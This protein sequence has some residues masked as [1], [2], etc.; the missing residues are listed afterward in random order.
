MPLPCKNAYLQYMYPD[1]M[2]S[3]QT[4]VNNFIIFLIIFEPCIA[5]YLYANRSDQNKQKSQ[6]GPGCMA[7]SKI[8]HR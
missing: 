3:G 2:A 1:Q 5:E 7:A 6:C 8:L 4:F